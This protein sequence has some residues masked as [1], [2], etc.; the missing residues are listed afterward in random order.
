LPDYQNVVEIEKKAN[1][2][3]TAVS[4]T[5]VKRA[6]ELEQFSRI[7]LYSE[8]ST[9]GDIQYIYMFLAIGVL[10]LFIAS[11]NFMNLSTARSARRANEVGL[12]KVVGANQWQLI[13]QFLGESVI[14]SFLA[15]ILALFIVYHILPIFKYITGQELFFPVL[16]DWKFYGFLFLLAPGVGILSGS[17]PALYLSAFHP[18]SILKGQMGPSGILY[19]PEVWR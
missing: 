11:I 17:Y 19:S 7:H 16:T 2:V 10:I 9:F 3:L 4:S 15:L 1:E 14:L 6:L 8:I 13:R 18:I 12:R 5:E